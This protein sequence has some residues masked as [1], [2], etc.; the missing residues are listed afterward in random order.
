MGFW[1]VVD[2]VEWAALIR[3]ALVAVDLGEQGAVDQ[4]LTAPQNIN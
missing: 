2:L 4:G 1:A 3:E